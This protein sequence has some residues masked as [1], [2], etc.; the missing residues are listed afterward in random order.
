[1]HWNCI[2]FIGFLVDGLVIAVHGIG[3]PDLQTYLCRF[4]CE[5]AHERSGPPKS[6]NMSCIAALHL[7]VAAHIK[8][9]R[10]GE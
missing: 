6:A 5:G 3:Y 8:D 7:D 9:N 10:N 4:I 2:L 1:M